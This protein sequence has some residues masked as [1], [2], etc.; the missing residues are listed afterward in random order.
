MIKQDFVQMYQE[1]QKNGHMAQFECQRNLVDL[2][3]STALNMEIVK[4]DLQMIFN[5]FEQ[6]SI[7]NEFFYTFEEYAIFSDML[8]KINFIIE[9]P[10]EQVDDVDYVNVWNE[11]VE[12]WSNDVFVTSIVYIDQFEK[13][14]ITIDVSIDNIDDL[15]YNIKEMIEDI[16]IYEKKVT[17]WHD[18]FSMIERRK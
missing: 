6:Y 4:N 17:M 18:F 10:A 16:R 11:I 14:G 2:K 7:M 15:I 12:M 5:T 13:D 8:K 9:L 3:A 1:Y